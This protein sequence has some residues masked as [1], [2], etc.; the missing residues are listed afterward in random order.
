MTFLCTFDLCHFL[1]ILV[2]SVFAKSY[3]TD[4]FTIRLQTNA[5]RLVHQ[6]HTFLII[7]TIRINNEQEIKSKT[8]AQLEKLCREQNLY[9]SGNKATLINRLLNPNYRKNKRNKQSV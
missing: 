6:I 2:N 8:V 4:L 5:C 1:Q 7:N 3:L 9:R